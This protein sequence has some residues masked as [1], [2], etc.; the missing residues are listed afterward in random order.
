MKVLMYILK[1]IVFIVIFVS[2]R[3]CYMSD[4]NKCDNKYPDFSQ[5]IRENIKSEFGHLAQPLS[6]DTAAVRQ[7][8]IDMQRMYEVQEDLKHRQ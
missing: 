2:V 7:N 6:I 5:E 4:D 1:I 8:F 3:Y